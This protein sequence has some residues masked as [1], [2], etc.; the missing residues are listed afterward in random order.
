MKFK[1]IFTLAMIILSSSLLHAEPKTLI[2]SEI[3][4]GGYIAPVLKF[5]E[6][7]NELGI[8]GGYKLGWIINHKYSIG[9]GGNMLINNPDKMQDMN[10]NRIHLGYMGGLLEYIINPDDLIHF[11]ISTLIGWGRAG[12][13]ANGSM[14]SGNINRFF[15]AEPELNLTINILKNLRFNI[16]GGYRF[17]TG[18]KVEGISDK[19]L[20][21]VTGTVA[22]Q[23]G[24]F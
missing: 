6:I 17:V 24:I 8:F 13:Y 16:G 14:M 20:S 19:G 5:S 1:M 3:E 23:A 22:I 10:S 18:S 15:V 12:S 7:N 2:N 9:L 4:N 21:G 11:S